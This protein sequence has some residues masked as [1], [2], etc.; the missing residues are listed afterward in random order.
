METKGLYTTQDGKTARLKIEIKEG[1]QLQVMAMSRN[2]VWD[3]LTI[4]ADLQEGALQEC[5]KKRHPHRI[6]DPT[7]IEKPVEG[8]QSV[9]VEDKMQIVDRVRTMVEDMQDRVSEFFIEVAKEYTGNPLCEVK[10][11]N[12]TDDRLSI[13]K[14][15]D[16]TVA[17]VIESRTDFNNV[18]WIFSK[19]PNAL[20]SSNLVSLDEV[21]GL[22]NEH[23]NSKGYI[24]DR[25][26][27]ITQIKNLN[28]K[29]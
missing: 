3:W 24:E 20:Q 26:T 2:G 16:R 17:T 5:I 12:Q 19:L 21:V 18:E 25:A 10:T 15:D 28:Q 13:L 4:D 29:A 14:I 22:I 23:A 6:I 27:L 7:A 11:Y 1:Q 9:S 8:K